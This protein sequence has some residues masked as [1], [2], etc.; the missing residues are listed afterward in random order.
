MSLPQ[1]LGGFLG[2]D[3][4]KSIESFWNTVKIAYSVWRWD[5]SHRV[6]TA[7]ARA[8]SGTFLGSGASSA[9]YELKAAASVS[10][11]GLEVT[12]L[13][14]GFS[15]V[16]T[17][18]STVTFVGMENITPLFRLHKVTLLRNIDPAAVEA[19]DLDM[20]V[21]AETTLQEDD[22]KPGE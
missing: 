18:S 15:L 20:P 8:D 4:V 12:N 5:R 7:V 3:S 16:S 22:T 9:S 13:A 17:A 21:T 1:W 19:T 2:L 14:A 11:H 10:V 6:V